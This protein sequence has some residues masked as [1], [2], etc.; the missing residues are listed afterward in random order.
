MHCDTRDGKNFIIEVQLSE[1]TYFSERAIFYSAR[2]VAQKA[3]QGGGTTTS[4]RYSSWVSSTSTCR[5][6]REK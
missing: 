3:E 4:L 1:Q 5:I 2:A 6:C